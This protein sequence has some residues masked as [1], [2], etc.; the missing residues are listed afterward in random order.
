MRPIALSR[1]NAAL[2]VISQND[3]WCSQSNSDVCNALEATAIS[4]FSIGPGLTRIG[5]RQQQSVSAPTPEIP[6]CDIRPI[7]LPHALAVD[8]GLRLPG[9]LGPHPELTEGCDFSNF[10]P[11]P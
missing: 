3:V 6:P 10:Q 2:V 5:R 8:R 9:R 1:V 4:D 11:C 7:T